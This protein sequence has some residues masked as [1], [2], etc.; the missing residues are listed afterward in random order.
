MVKMII[1][2]LFAVAG[3]V[4]WYIYCPNPV[5]KDFHAA[6][7]SGKPEAITSFLDMAALKRGTS[8]FV[9]ARYSRPD[10]PGGDLKPEEIQAIVDGFLTPA[11]IILLMKGVKLSPGSAAS[12]PPDDPKNHPIEEHYE[13]PQVYAIDIYLSP[14]QTPD[15]KVSL[16]FE[17]D[18]WFDW[19]LAFIRFSWN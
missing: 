11:N 9:K 5:M 8:D 3:V 12:G 16:L 19:K 2:F 14:V 6:V 17:R 15:N 18:G 13:S 7:D 1:G 10:V 4:G